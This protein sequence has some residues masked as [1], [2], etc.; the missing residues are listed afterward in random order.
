MLFPQPHPNPGLADEAMA[1]PAIARFKELHD[2]LGISGRHSS[3]HLFY[4]HP[5]FSP[6]LIC[7]MNLAVRCVAHLRIVV[8]PQITWRSSRERRWPRFLTHPCHVQAV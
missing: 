7:I 8:A 6:H 2:F 3:R 5:R 1:V 4:Y